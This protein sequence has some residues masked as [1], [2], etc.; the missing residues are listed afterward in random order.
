MLYYISSRDVW[1]VQNNNDILHSALPDSKRTD[2]FIFKGFCK[3]SGLVLRIL[4]SFPAPCR[5]ILR[6]GKCADNNM[7]SAKRLV[8]D[9]GI[10]LKTPLTKII[11]NELFSQ[12]TRS[13]K[14]VFDC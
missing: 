9:N 10:K 13:G 6:A 3:H 4:H 2:I 1:D 5:H 7:A 12:Y 11:N 14:I 8:W